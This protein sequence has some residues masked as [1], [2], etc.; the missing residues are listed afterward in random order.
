MVVG[1]PSSVNFC[2]LKA[3]SLEKVGNTN[4]GPVLVIDFFLHIKSCFLIVRELLSMCKVL[5]F[6]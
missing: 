3:V 5:H 2:L 4:N 1:G 6:K